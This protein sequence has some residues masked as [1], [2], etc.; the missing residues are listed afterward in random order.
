MGKFIYH[1]FEMVITSLPIVYMAKVPSATQ[2]SVTGLS[3]FKV[4]LPSHPSELSVI[5]SIDCRVGASEWVR[6]SSSLPSPS[7]NPSL[8]ANNS[9]WGT[10]QLWNLK[11]KFPATIPSCIEPGNYF[12]RA[13]IIALHGE[14]SFPVVKQ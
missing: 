13:E 12:L 1:H 6:I 8:T 11:G 14:S 3:W 7:I 2:T 5:V 4:C 9:T 10:Q